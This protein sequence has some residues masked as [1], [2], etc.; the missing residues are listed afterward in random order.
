M[1][2]LRLTD[3]E[4]QQL[5]ERLAPLILSALG[6]SVAGACGEV[7]RWMRTAEAAEYLGMSKSELHRRAAAGVVPHAQEAPGAAL[8]FRRADLDAW[9]RG[10][11]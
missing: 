10:E 6:D 5:A 11:R 8:Y 3:E 9:R 7:D 2:E 1:A 4:L